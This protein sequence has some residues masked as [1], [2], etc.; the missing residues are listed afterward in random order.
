METASSLLQTLSNNNSA[1]ADKQKEEY[2]QL[3]PEEPIEEPALEEP[4]ITE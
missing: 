4:T 1:I 2:R 3:F